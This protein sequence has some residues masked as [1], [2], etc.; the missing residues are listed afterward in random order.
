MTA[1]AAPSPEL[2]E[3]RLDRLLQAQRL[4]QH[5]RHGEERLGVLACALELA[6][7]VV[8]AEEAGMLAVR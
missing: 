3:D 2:V 7:V 5:L 6:D 4:P 8:D 1:D